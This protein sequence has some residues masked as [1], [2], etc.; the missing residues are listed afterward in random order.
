MDSLPILSE[1]SQRRLVLR[2][3]KETAPE[4]FGRLR[5]SQPTLAELD[6][7]MRETVLAGL[8]F[9]WTLF[10]PVA[11]LMELIPLWRIRRAISRHGPAWLAEPD[12]EVAQLIVEGAIRRVLRHLPRS[13][14]REA[15]GVGRE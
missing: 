9:I 10:I 6:K 5:Q 3:A 12:A 11:A 8:L 4:V 13:R 1:E 2:A 15:R 14:R 7:Q